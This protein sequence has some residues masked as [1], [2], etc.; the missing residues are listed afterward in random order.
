MKRVFLLVLLVAASC[1]GLTG[2]GHA[3]VGETLLAQ[4]DSSKPL[5]E[6]PGPISVVAIPGGRRG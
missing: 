5:P 2:P 1:K 4:A 6:N 3:K